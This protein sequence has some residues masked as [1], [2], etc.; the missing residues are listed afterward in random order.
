[1][2]KLTLFA[3]AVLL[4]ALA[5]VG[6]APAAEQPEVYQEDGVVVEGYHHGGWGRH[7]GWRQDGGR[8]G[9]GGWH[10]GGGRHYQGDGCWGGR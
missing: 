7:R 3:G 5:L 10:H 4:A 2:K 6:A 1:M 9:G 8:R